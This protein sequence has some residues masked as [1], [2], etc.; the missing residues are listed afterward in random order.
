MT[1]RETQIEAAKSAKNE[2]E[3]EGFMDPETENDNVDNVDEVETTLSRPPVAESDCFHLPRK[4]RL[5]YVYGDLH[6]TP[7]PQVL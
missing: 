3:E 7:L 4:G 5:G 2:V 1:K 6:P